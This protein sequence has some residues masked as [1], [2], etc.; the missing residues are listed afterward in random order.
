M[1]S[2]PERQP[3]LRTP[4]QQP[5]NSAE[6]RRVRIM[7]CVGYSM[8]MVDLAVDTRRASMLT[9]ALLAGRTTLVQRARR[10]S[11]G[12]RGGRSVFTPPRRDSHRAHDRH[13]NHVY[14]F[15]LWTN[16]CL[17]IIR[18]VYYN[19]Y[20]CH[21]YSYNYCHCRAYN[22]NFRFAHAQDWQQSWQRPLTFH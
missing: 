4:P 12:N 8:P 20:L 14:A 22:C 1:R 18:T 16:L 13:N 2:L 15:R 7:S 9:G 17:S 6:D 5:A 11:W 19:N 3:R 21:A 10:L